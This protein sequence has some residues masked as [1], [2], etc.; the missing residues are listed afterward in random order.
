LRLTGY[1]GDSGDS[2]KIHDGMAFSTYD[3]DHD[4]ISTV[5]C[6][7]TFTGAWWFNRCHTSNLNGQNFG[8]AE[9]TPDGKGI[10]WSKFSGQNYTLKNVQMAIR[11]MLNLNDSN[12]NETTTTEATTTNTTKGN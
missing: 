12:D 3:R 7:E 8:V 2:F 10:I 1:H 9:A 6:A 5:N 11:P 4:N